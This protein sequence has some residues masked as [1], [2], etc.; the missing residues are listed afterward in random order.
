MKSDLS[1]MKRGGRAVAFLLATVISA[2]VG[3]FVGALPKPTLDLKDGDRVVLIGD[4]LIEREQSYGYVEERLTVRFP[5]RNVTFRNLGWSADTP[6][7]ISRASFDFDKPG[8]GFEKLKEQIETLQPTVVIVGYGMA[9]S[10]DGEAGLPKFKADLNKLLDTIQTVCTNKSL[11]FIMLT[12]VRHEAL[13]APLPDPTEH[14]K[15]LALY[16]KAV[17]EIAT[18]RKAYYVSLYNNLLGDGTLVR[19]PHA[20]TEN[21]IHLSD[22]GYLRMA[23]AM[24]KGFVWEPN[25]W[26]VEITA[27]GKIT[28]GSY[29]TKV[30][31]L[32]KGAD[33]VRFTSI[34]LQLVEPVLRDNHGLVHTA[35]APSLVQVHGLK[36][37]HYELRVDGNVVASGTEKDW[38]KGVA[39]TQGPQWDQA[40]EL[41]KAILKKNRLYFDRW[42]PQNETYLFG[43]RKYEQGQNAKEIPMF[44]PLVAEQ[45]Q[46]I[47][48]LRMPVAHNFEL[49]RVKKSEA[50][51]AKNQVKPDNSFRENTKPLPLPDFDVAPGFE[52]SL[53]AESPLIAK[54]TQ[55][56]FDPQGRLWVVGSEVYPQI[57]PGQEANDKVLILEDTKGV[58]K[59][60]K[61]TVFADGL[62]IPTGVEPGDGGVYVGQG[63]QL[64]HFKDTDGDG[65]ADQKRIVLSGFGTEDTH[66]IVH[67][68]HWGPDGMLYFDQSIYIH[69]HME[70]QNGVERLNS[71]G[72]WH[73]RPSTVELGVYLKGFCNPWGHQFDDFGQSFVTDGAGNQG[74]TYGIPG[75]TYFTYASMRRELKSVSPGNYPKFCGLEIIYSKQFPDDWQGNAITCDFRAHRVVRFAVD[76]KDSAYA[77]KEL[78]DLIRSTNV[79]FRP[80]DVKLGPDGALY[81][82]D[83]SNPI[84]Q[85]GEVDFRDPRR[86][87]EHGR[88]WRVAAKGRPLLKRPELVKA[89]NK[90]LFEQLVS[91]NKYNQQQAKRVLVERG[92][93]IVPDLVKWTKEQKDETALLQALWMYQAVDVVEPALLDRMLEAKDGHI[94]AAATRVVSYWHPRLKNP[95]ELLEKRSMDDFPRVRIEAARALAE[96]PSARS[97][98]LVLNI[99]NKPMDPFLDYAVWLSINDLAKP[100]LDAVQ[101]GQWNPAGREKQ[102]EFAL[103]AIEP[104]QAN[105]VLGQV[106]SKTAIQRDGNGPWIEL[107]GQAGSEKELK[108]LF[109]QL[110]DGGLDAEASVRALAALSDAMKQRNA[111]PS[112][113]LDGV[114]KLFADSDEKI[115]KV[116]LRLAGTW[117]CSGL[118]DQILAIATDKKSTEGTKRAAFDGLREMGGK[119]IVAKLLPLASKEN[120]AVVRRGSVMALAGLD[121]EQAKQPLISLLSDAKTEKEAVELWRSLLGIKGASTA[122]AKALPKEGL[123]AVMAK[124][125]LKV[126]REGGR[127]EP[128]LVV[129]LTRGADLEGE[130]QGLSDAEMR[131]LAKTS[132]REGDAKLGEQIFRRKEIGCVN[133]HAIGG[134]GGKVGP[135]LTSIGASAQPDYL[136]ESVFYPNRKIKEGYHSLLIET[137]DGE[138]ISGI[139][140][141]ENNEQ[142][143]LRDTTDKEVSIPKNNIKNRKMGNSLMPSGLIDSLSSSE[144]LNLFRFLSDLGKPGTYDASKGNVARL[145]RLYPAT[146]DVAQF[147][148]DKVLKSKL[149]DGGWTQ[150]YTLVDGHL[151]KSDLQAALDSVKDRDPKAVYAAAQL[152]VP[153]NGTVHLAL[154]GA[155]GCGMWVDGNPMATGKL[156]ELTAGN[157]VVIVKLDSKKLPDAVRLETPDGTFLTN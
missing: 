117:K 46:K 110:L 141:R 47:A 29:G 48:Q 107:I 20:N 120:D 125:G 118:S 124:A 61:S 38:E 25:L 27:E 1:H 127:N 41:R 62:L 97:A 135:D 148:D 55:M 65:K 100:W 50:N 155:D 10:F 64:I 73:L 43:F 116:A 82:A 75:A 114:S 89:S 103:K 92:V 129:A 60:D 80:I 14:N 142:L 44:D 102:L 79:T 17:N 134:V 68:L 72:I 5:E 147:G 94:R 119:E 157:H 67:T 74:I 36:T 45:E 2:T 101:S 30:S 122:V 113:D 151:M 98:E 143:V 131:L 63:T 6:E 77:S 106:L 24:E 28:D 39:I 81:I 105:I 19:P 42:R 121:M 108:R 23:E 145:W 138:E 140:V 123:P 156:P 3:S 54:P 32:E 9:S 37:G 13:G 31:K 91:P 34:D 26:R 76:E 53:Y 40:E 7:G 71:G 35:D 4:T 99:L 59:V 137:K 87:H 109:D 57:Q 96:M 69:S 133:C 8:K 33:Q 51:V 11:R 93:K 86:D 132:I 150:A 16:A 78:P 146:I 49:V 139:L 85:H 104:A 18:E 88:I 70:T 22:Y 58:G 66:H 52:V 95:M 21:G 154:T 56:N 149:T 12:P 83:W 136:V 112:G 111:K 115:R 152:Q 128:D 130:G 15:N 153:R 144:R 84:I 126:A 90:E